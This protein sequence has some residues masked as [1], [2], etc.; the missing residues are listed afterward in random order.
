MTDW[1]LY[2]FCIEF[3]LWAAPNS[4]RLLVDAI[5][6][7]LPNNYKETLH[8]FD[9]NKLKWKPYLD[10]RIDPKYL[11]WEHIISSLNCIVQLWENCFLLLTG[12]SLVEQSCWNKIPT[13]GQSEIFNHFVITFHTSFHILVWYTNL[14]FLSVLPNG[15][16]TCVKS[17]LNVDRQVLNNIMNISLQTIK[18]IPAIKV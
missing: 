17:A 14:L 4:F 10:K 8:L 2:K 11:P 6:P 15:R 13:P 12:S 3:F 18:K 7:V 9:S 1:L 5:R 16:M